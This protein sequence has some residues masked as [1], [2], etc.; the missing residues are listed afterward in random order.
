MERKPD[1]TRRRGLPSVLGMALTLALAA[2][3]QAPEPAGSVTVLPKVTTAS[4]AVPP[5]PPVAAYTPPPPGSPCLLL[6]KIQEFPTKF[7]GTMSDPAYLELKAA[8]RDALPCLVDELANPTPLE[9]EGERTVLPVLTVGDLA[10]FVLVDFGY[11]D[12]LRAMPPDVLAQTTER[13]VFAYFDWIG[14]PGHR[15]LLQQRVRQQ[16]GVQ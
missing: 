14:A 12:Y 4:A 13:G 10:F 9:E 11:V 15:A 3:S 1:T 7:G 2:C 6:P 16:V 5:A 8:G